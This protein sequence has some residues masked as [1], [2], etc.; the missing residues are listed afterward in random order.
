MVQAGENLWVS[1][2]TDILHESVM[3]FGYRIGLG[4]SVAVNDQFRIDAGARAET[5]VW[6][7]ASDLPVAGPLPAPTHLDAVMSFSLAF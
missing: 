6:H 4:L 5:I 2:A 3:R 1:T 7:V